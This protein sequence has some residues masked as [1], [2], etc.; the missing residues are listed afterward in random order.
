MTEIIT[1]KPTR[2]DCKACGEPCWWVTLWNGQKV[3]IEKKRITIINKVKD[4]VYTT[5]GGYLSHME[6]CPKEGK[7]HENDLNR[8]T[9]DHGRIP[10]STSSIS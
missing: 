4:E 6:Q 10:Q 3:L 7:P 5:T 2:T 9:R 8:S 1:T